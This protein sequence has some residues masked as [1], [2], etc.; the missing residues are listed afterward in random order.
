[1]TGEIK[2]V[3]FLSDFDFWY[4][5]VLGSTS[6]QSY[7]QGHFEGLELDGH[8][9]CGRCLCDFVGV[10]HSN[11]C[12]CHGIF[13]G[14]HV[15]SLLWGNGAFGGVGRWNI[16]STTSRRRSQSGT[17]A[18]LRRCRIRGIVINTYIC[19]IS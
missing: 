11:I 2:D 5:A 15:C 3:R 6:S 16:R 1:M 19:T 18:L 12:R 9:I 4:C 7:L 8:W 14:N 13:I 17:A 10:C